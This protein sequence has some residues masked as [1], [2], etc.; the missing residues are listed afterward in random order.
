[1]AVS[2]IKDSLTIYLTKLPLLMKVVLLLLS[3]SVVIWFVFDWTHQRDVDAALKDFLQQDLQQTAA[4]YQER[5]DGYLRTQHRTARLLVQREAFVSYLASQWDQP[6]VGGLNNNVPIA[7]REIPKWL[8]EKEVLHGLTPGSYFLL[9]DAGGVLRETYRELSSDIAD[10]L[11]PNIVHG[12]VANREDSETIF[13]SGDAVYLVTNIKA[14]DSARVVKAFLVVV[15]PLDD[16]FLVLLRKQFGSDSIMV[17]I[18][19]DGRHVLASSRP[20]LIPSGSLVAELTQDYLLQQQTFFNHGFSSTIKIQMATLIAL[21]RVDRLH[22]RVD[23]IDRRLRTAGFGILLA[24]FLGIIQWLVWRI[25]AFTTEISLFS[26]EHLGSSMTQGSGRDQLTIMGDQFHLMKG[27]VIEGRKRLQEREQELTLANKSLWESLVM[28]KKAQSK[29]LESEKMAYLG[30]LVAGVAHEINTPVG[31]GITAASFLEQKCRDIHALCNTGGMKKSDL[32]AFIEVARESSEMV[33]NNLQRAAEL[34]RSF[35]QVAVDQS[36]EE[37]RRFNVHEYIKYLFKSLHHRLKKTKIIV[38][39]ECPEDLQYFGLP[40]V[41]SQIITNLVENSLIHGFDEDEEGQIHLRV[42]PFEGKIRFTYSDTGRGI[43]GDSIKHIFEPFFTT[44]RN[45]GGS[46]LGLHIVY[47]LVTQTLGGSI[48][49]QSTP[50]NGVSF[51]ME[52]QA[53][54]EVFNG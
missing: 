15:T 35:K 9:F 45:K 46:G 53:H 33:L 1:M 20:D 37:K 41:L 16:Q 12:V 38:S 44:A 42:E 32:I 22:Q 30:S 54:E 28:V 17:F 5:L 10:G 6:G 14:I 18:H 34:I 2:M 29:L 51:I 48:D 52:F 49:C 13:M 4:I 50:G 19:Q 21:D 31:I 39:T 47:N 7:H 8:A 40:G 11:Q 3:V 24:V 43:S 27:T 23:E 36:N 25:Q 26:K